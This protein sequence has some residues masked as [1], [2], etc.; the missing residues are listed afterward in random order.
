MLYF[1]FIQR[2][3]TPVLLVRDQGAWKDL[4]RVSLYK[5]KGNTLNENENMEMKGSLFL[6]KHK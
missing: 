5:K 2:L 6:S 1:C 3:L 4:L